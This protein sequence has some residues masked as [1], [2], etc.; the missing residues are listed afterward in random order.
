M[1]DTQAMTDTQIVAL[2]PVA[3]A[4]L[5]RLLEAVTASQSRLTI[6]LH[7]Y[8][9]AQGI[10]DVVIDKIDLEGRALVVRAA[11]ERYSTDYLTTSP[12]VTGIKETGENNDETGTA[13]H[14][15][16]C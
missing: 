11:P 15:G 7:G 4:K 8:L 10:E 13:Y 12:S 3:A 6:F 2:T 5:R 1:T 16:D 14:S 9:A